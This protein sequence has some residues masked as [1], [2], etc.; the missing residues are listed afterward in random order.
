MSN[1]ILD[2]DKSRRKGIIVS[3][4][5]DLIRLRFS[6]PNEAKEI[7]KRRFGGGM[8]ADRINAITA[9]G[10][11]DL[12]MYFEIAKF[13]K[14]SQYG[15]QYNT[16]QLL[17]DR[18]KLGVNPDS[19]PKL[20]LEP[21]EYQV[22]GVEKALKYGFGTFV[23]GTGGG[24][25]LL[26]ALIDRTIHKQ[27]SG[28]TLI[29]LPA[30]LVQQTKKD[31][32][33]YGIPAEDIACWSGIK[34]PYEVK[35]IIIASYK[36]IGSKLTSKTP[37]IQKEFLEKLSDVSV[38]MLDEV[39][40]LR[41]KNKLNKVLD[42]LKDISHRFGFTGT[43]PEEPIDQWNIIGRIGPILID[44]DTY[45]LR[46]KGNLSQVKSLILKIHYSELPDQTSTLEEPNR[47][48]IVEK[49]FITANVYR[50]N[51]IKQLCKSFQDNCLIMVDRLEHGHL[52]YEELDQIE[53]K[54]CYWIY[55]DIDID[56]RE[57][58]RALMEVETNIICIA[59]AKIFSTGIN[60]KNLHYVIMAQGGKAKVTIVQSIGRGLRLHELK[61]GLVIVD[62]ADM[63]RYGEDHL[64]K[65]ELLY[66]KEN[67]TYETR[68]IHEPPNNN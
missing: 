30:S 37:A 41:K 43:L 55:G 60:I 64:Q 66:N 61:A 58:I 38:L 26:M 20:N 16:T 21:R 18:L 68:D 4:H 28:S 36:T 22:D 23:L 35:P 3:D 7:I 56:E 17:A 62:L 49:E 14:N 27:V 13:I 34:N 15:F 54:Q 24:K 47:A 5:L 63:L 53:G 39:H 9:T 8:I 52:L 42:K 10:R 31:F 33:D 1:V 40:R 45:E 32:I 59:M 44:M 6:Q 48:Y 2:W 12:G 29:C 67:I 50:R 51:V 65:R 57:R 19:L 11:F 46:Q 25:T